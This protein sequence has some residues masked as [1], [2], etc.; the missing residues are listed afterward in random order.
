MNLEDMEVDVHGQ[1]DV[2]PECMEAGSVGYD[3]PLPECEAPLVLPHNTRRVI[4]TGV[5]IRPPERCFEMVVPRSSTYNMNLRISNTVGVI[6][7]SYCGQD[8]TIKVSI[9]R[10]PEQYEFLESVRDEDMKARTIQGHVQEEYDLDGRDVVYQSVE[11]EGGREWHVF[12]LQQDDPVVYESGERFC[13]VL[14][15]PFH[16]PDLV[17]KERQAFKQDDR[18]GFGSTS[19]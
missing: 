1:Y 8:D 4:D 13:Q 10:G 12:A 14:F 19:Q 18:G 2:I 16:K 5:I 15:L 11:F 3:I 9:E 6:D 7:P 17:E